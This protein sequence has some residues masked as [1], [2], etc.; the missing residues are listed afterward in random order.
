MA[1]TVFDCA[2]VSTPDLDPKDPNMLGQ[3]A[4]ITYT[5]P[6]AARYGLQHSPS[7]VEAGPLDAK[8][9]YIYKPL[10]ANATATPTRTSTPTRTPTPTSTRVVTKWLDLAASGKT[11]HADGQATLEFTAIVT[12]LRHWP[13]ID[14]A[15][16]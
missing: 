9:W 2:V 4:V 3:Q 6:A 11:V 15:C 10:P 8:V 14:Q 12:D 7:H 13:A 5:V 16:R 1:A